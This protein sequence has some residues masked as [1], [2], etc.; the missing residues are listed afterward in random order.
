MRSQSRYVQVSVEGNSIFGAT[1]NLS[2][3]PDF[4]RGYGP[5]KSVVDGTLNGTRTDG[6]YR[7]AP[8]SVDVQRGEDGATQVNGLFAGAKLSAFTISPKAFQGHLGSCSY[9]LT[10]NGTRYEGSS[11]CGGSIELT[12]LELPVAMA[13]WSDLESATALAIVLGT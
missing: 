11:S 8:F 6:N 10:F 7:N 12:S 3:G 13:G 2:H 1:W 5:G 9:D 4:I